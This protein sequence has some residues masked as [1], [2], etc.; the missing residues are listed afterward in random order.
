MITRIQ[1]FDRREIDEDK[2]IKNIFPAAC[3]VISC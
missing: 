1:L 2:Q 3:C